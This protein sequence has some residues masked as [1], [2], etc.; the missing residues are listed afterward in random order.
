[1]APRELQSN[2][3]LYLLADIWDEIP[4]YEKEVLKEHGSL[5]RNLPCLCE[6]GSYMP[7]SI[8]FLR[9]SHLNGLLTPSTNVLQV[10]L[11]NDRKWRFLAEMGVSLEPTLGL[12]LEQIRGIKN[13]GLNGGSLAKAA[14]IYKDL[15]M[16]CLRNQNHLT[17]LRFY[18]T[19]ELTNF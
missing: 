3:V 12:F 6:N 18:S 14:N 13:E 4:H 7:L 15:V 19:S 17:A 11:P 16:F 10:E 8:C 9:T 5:V 1:M 2:A